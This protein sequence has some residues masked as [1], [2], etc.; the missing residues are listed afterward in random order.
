MNT[1]LS[2]VLSKNKINGDDKE[3][4]DELKLL[5]SKY[6]NNDSEYTMIRY[7]KKYLTNDMTKKTGLFRSVIIYDG[8][9]LCYSPPKSLS[10][11]LFFDN[12]LQDSEY[13]VAEELVE[14]TMINLF[15]DTANKAG[16]CWEIA[17]RS[18]VGAKCKFWKTDDGLTFRRM[19]LDVCNDV[20]FEFDALD[21]RCCYSFV[22]QHPSNKIVLPI[23]YTKLYLVAAYELINNESIL[24]IRY[25]DINTVIKAEGFINTDVKIP[26]RI[27]KDK[28]SEWKI[29]ADEYSSGNLPYDKL[30]VVFKNTLTGDR[31]K[32]RN[33][34]YENI[35]RLRGNQA[36]LQYQYLILRNEGKVH[37][38]LQYFPE[39]K[40]ELNEFKAQIHLYT[41]GL[42]NNYV[43]CF[44]KHKKKLE[45][46]PAN[47]K[48]HMYTLHKL[49]LDELR[50][51]KE[52]VGL[53]VVINYF[54]TLHPSKQMHILN[55]SNRQRN[56]DHLQ[57][58][59]L[60]QSNKNINKT[61]NNQNTTLD[62]SDDNNSI[63]SDNKY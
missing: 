29:L 16:G 1:S 36:K 3:I 56:L 14:G 57:V 30:G 26:E 52:Y 23:K 42:H 59:L 41:K 50:E 31:C 17:T 39:C 15:W 34:I 40:Q 43:D 35:H 12:F 13:V 10:I 49:Y 60:Q 33:P 51:R 28:W 63:S 18:T 38:Y 4:W 55:Y 46:Y 11:H 54:N 61:D 32:V 62:C 48:P 5:K 53:P 9:I 47:F 44:I 58:E 45:E 25:I 20:N 24:G 8:K 2:E 21:K 22:M 6:S 27:S 19:F 7:D 37:D